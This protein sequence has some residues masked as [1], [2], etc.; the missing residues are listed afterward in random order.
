MDVTV[1][2]AFVRWRAAPRWSRAAPTVGLFDRVATPD[3]VDR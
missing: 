3:D 2:Q 1:P